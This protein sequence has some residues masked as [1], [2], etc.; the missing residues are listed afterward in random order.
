MYLESME[1]RILRPQ[2]FLSAMYLILNPWL[3]LSISAYLDFAQNSRQ[4][5]RPLGLLC[6]KRATLRDQH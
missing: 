2:S 3:L 6:P 1:P 4:M 5:A